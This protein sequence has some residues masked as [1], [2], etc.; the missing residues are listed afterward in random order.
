MKYTLEQLIK[1]L[2]AYYPL[3]QDCKDYSGKARDVAPASSISY[4]PGPPDSGSGADFLK[5][6][7]V[8]LLPDSFEANTDE[9]SLMAWV[10]VSS[11][12]PV[13]SEQNDEGVIVGGLRLVRGTGKVRFHFLYDAQGEKDI[14]LESRSRIPLDDWT[15]VAVTYKKS[16]KELILYL[17]GKAD[18]AQVLTL[19]D[20]AKPM[21]P[22][23]KSIGAYPD[24][25]S[26]LNG[27]VSDVAMLWAPLEQCCVQVFANYGV[28]VRAGDDDENLLWFVVPLIV[29]GVAYI[30]GQAALFNQVKDQKSD[31]LPPDQDPQSIS[32]R[33]RKA[34]GE[35][36]RRGARVSRSDVDILPDTTIRIDVGGM[37][38][39]HH[40]VQETLTGLPNTLN[41][42]DKGTNPDTRHEGEKNIPN[43]ILVRKWSNDPGYPF[44][45]NFA[46]YITMQNAPLTDTNVREI[47]R[48]LKSDGQVG[49]WI[50]EATFRAN[51]D[52]LKNLLGPDY[53][54]I[55]CVE[56]DRYLD[57]MDDAFE[58]SKILLARKKASV[59]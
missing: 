10:K 6:G 1:M 33:I 42:N 44:A 11:Y 45:D 16:N 58:P 15:H 49:L 5:S 43:L 51:I 34:V 57:E 9:Y 18:T 8:L 52:A 50:D 31:P 4:S 54:E 29:V 32:D 30:I 25:G 26:T 22:A 23:G 41:M 28:T 38:V 7:E 27:S 20:G 3:N 36:A 47:A 40:V 56:E 14:I 35:P 21:M 55:K 37:G 48:V 46:D 24:S 2:Q 12:D 13:P 59:R 17:D 19:P 39:Y 53:E